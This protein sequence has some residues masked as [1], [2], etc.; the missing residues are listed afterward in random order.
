MRNIFEKV[1][2]N[3]K[4]KKDKTFLVTVLIV[5]LIVGAMAY[6]LYFFI[7]YF[8]SHNDYMVDLGDSFIYAEHND[9]FEVYIDDVRYEMDDITA[10]RLF[11]VFNR[12]WVGRPSKK[13]NHEKGIHISFGDGTTLFLAETTVHNKYTFFEEDTPAFYG[14]YT[15]RNNRVY[16]FKNYRFPYR[17]LVEIIKGEA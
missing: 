17:Y 15:D 11:M 14:E 6:S 5:S 9:S 4:P 2:K 1:D 12:A 7:D 8:N 16:I 13:E 3:S 10:Q